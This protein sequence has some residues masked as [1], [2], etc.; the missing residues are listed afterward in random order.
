[1]S[2]LKQENSFFYIGIAVTVIFSI[3]FTTLSPSIA[4]GDSGE[5]VAEGCHLGTAHPPGYPVFTIFVNLL[6]RNFGNI[7]STAYL[8]NISSAL[9]TA[10][11]AMLI[12]LILNIYESR[13]IY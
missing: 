2:F 13:C 1:M 8:V 5:L 3:Y 6:H 7:F 12:G 4:G 11:S 9:F 10:L